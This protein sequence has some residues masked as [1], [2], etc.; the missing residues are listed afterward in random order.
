MG[1]ARCWI[2]SEQVFVLISFYTQE[3]KIKTKKRKLLQDKEKVASFY[4]KILAHRERER[5]KKLRSKILHKSSV[6]F[7]QAILTTHI[8]LSCL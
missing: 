4:L 6:N 8:Q 7:F 2:V 1:G 5:G 3:L